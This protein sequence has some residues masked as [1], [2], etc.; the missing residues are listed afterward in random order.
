MSDEVKAIS[1]KVRGVAAEK[2]CTQGRMADV[3]S[4]S[5]TTVADRYAARTPFTAPEL[6]ILSR[7]FNVPVSR[8]FPEGAAA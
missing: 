3:L 2:R 8:F 5:R 4:L 7:E 1:D 6:L